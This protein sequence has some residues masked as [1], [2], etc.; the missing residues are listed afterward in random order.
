MI[1]S[2]DRLGYTVTAALQNGL[3]AAIAG[4]VPLIS[5]RTVA[6]SS[7]LHDLR[8]G[9]LIPRSV[10]L[11]YTPLF[12]ILQLPSYGL[13]DLNPDAVVN[14]I[15]EPLDTLKNIFRSDRD[16][17]SL[18]AMLGRLLGF[19]S[20]KD[21][22]APLLDTFGSY[23]EG[24]FGIALS[25]VTTL[26]NLADPA[27]PRAIADAGLAYFFNADGFVTVDDIH[28][29]P[30][31]N[32]SGTAKT[33]ADLQRAM[34]PKTAERYVRDLITI[35]VEA[36]GDVQY[37]LRDRYHQMLAKLSSPQQ[38]VAK[39]W[40]KGFAAMAESGVMAAVE[41]TLLGIGQF[42]TNP[43]IAAIAGTYAGVVARKATQHVFL[44]ELG[45]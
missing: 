12:D 7:L 9:F 21:Y 4:K 23:L 35:T 20:T 22:F 30:P 24:Q 10:T 26:K 40:C 39:R 28:L 34:V 41:E 13:A 11:D 5:L 44:S 15:I 8:S 18:H 45:V 6:G 42:S 37:G 19:F 17:A 3:A 1:T 31:M 2:D 32:F 25:L 43:M 38:E 27:F 14:A 33:S 16:G 29:M 36:A